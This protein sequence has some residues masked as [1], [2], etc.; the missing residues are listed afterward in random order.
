MIIYHLSHL[1]REPGFTPPWPSCVVKEPHRPKFA[2]FFF[3]PEVWT[4]KHLQVPWDA[5]DTNDCLVFQRVLVGNFVLELEIHV[6][7]FLR[8]SQ[9]L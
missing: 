9:R 7:D 2:D 3:I 6:G 5:Y 4:T 8:E 1:W